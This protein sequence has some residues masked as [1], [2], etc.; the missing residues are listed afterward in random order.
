MSQQ[1]PKDRY[2]DIGGVNTR[3]W[4][5]GDEGRAVILIH[6]LGGPGADAQRP[7]SHL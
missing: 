1:M 2:V 4:A 6:G 7:G 5:A 3:Y